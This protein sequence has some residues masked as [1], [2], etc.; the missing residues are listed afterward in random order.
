MMK[1]SSSAPGVKR[2]GSL[3][4]SALGFSLLPLIICCSCSSNDSN[5]H[6]GSGG[7]APAGSNA[8]GSAG[9]GGG[10][11]GT[12]GAPTGTG[13]SAGTSG[14]SAGTAGGSAGTS[15][16]SAGTGGA[17]TGTGG[18]VT[19]VVAAGARW[20]GRVDVSDPTA[21]KFAWSGTGFIATVTGTEVSVSLRSVGGGDPIYFEPVIDG[22]PGTRFSVTTAEGAKTVSIGSG[23]TAGDHVVELYRE[24][25]GKLGFAYTTFAGFAAGTPADPPPYGGRLL[26]IIGDSISAGYGNLGSE[27]HPNFGP[28]PSGGCHFSTQTESAYMTYGA[29]AARALGA[30]ASIVAASGWG[31]YSD[32]QGSVTNTLPHIYSNTLG[33]QPAPVWDFALKPQAIVINLGTNDFAANPNLD[34]SSFTGAYTAFLTTVRGKNPDAWIYCAIGP[35][36]FG[37]GLANATS[38]IQALVASLNTNGDAKVKV[39]DFGQQ[40]TSLGTG[41][42]YHPNVT[43]QQRLADKLAAELRADLHW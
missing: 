17:P 27:Q 9:T 34:S 41:C 24:T 6:P 22:T 35:L 38:Y 28:D 4:G 2:R 43:E 42:D 7:S 32:N 15:G 10:S 11:A 1:A 19:P 40:N 8:G 20:I 31:I 30:D 25:E 37:P 14:G 26:E 5:T 36:L 18:A 13:G 3:V 33:G 21:V 29:L 23:L 39:L 12:G 16:G